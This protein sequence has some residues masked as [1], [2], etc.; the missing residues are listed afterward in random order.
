MSQTIDN[1][2]LSNTNDFH[3]HT[4]TTEWITAFRY[5]Y[6]TKKPNWN[7]HFEEI[8]KNYRTV[9]KIIQFELI[10]V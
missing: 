8:Q 4:N 10:E 9:N 5:L 1:S 7:Q 3:L 2:I 6:S